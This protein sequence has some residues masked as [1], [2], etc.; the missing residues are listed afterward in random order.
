GDIGTGIDAR[1]SYVTVQGNHFRNMGEMLHCTS[2]Q[3]LVENNIFENVQGYSDAI[4][5]DGERGAVSI[6]RGNVILGSE[7]DGIDLGGASP[8]M[9]RNWIENCADKGVSLEGAS[10]P[11]VINSVIVQCSMGIAVKDRCHAFLVHNTIASCQTGISLYEKNAN[12]GGGT[13]EIVN[14]LV[15]DA[16]QSLELDD[17]SSAVVSHSNLMQLPAAFQESN[18]SLDPLFQDVS[19]WR[20]DLQAG[21]PLIDAGR[22]TEIGSDY[23]GAVRPIGAAPDIGAYEYSNPT[24]IEKWMLHP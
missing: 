18:L 13:A 16:E 14:C 15:W 12:Q 6:I 21:S 4:D 5:F 22:Q 24:S 17:K 9:E 3:S 10:A 1:D 2:C 20:L 7:D 8:I 23:L 19:Q 11:E